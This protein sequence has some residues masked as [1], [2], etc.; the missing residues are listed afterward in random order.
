MSACGVSGRRVRLSLNFSWISSK[1]IVKRCV[2]FSSK[3]LQKNAVETPQIKFF[4][5]DKDIV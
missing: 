1:D 5:S 3:E 2:I 4:H